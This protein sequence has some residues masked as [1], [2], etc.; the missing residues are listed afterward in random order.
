[1]VNVV[2]S[3]YIYN[4]KFEIFNDVKKQQKQFAFLI[5]TNEYKIICK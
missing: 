1:M 2:M 3:T 5:L 4:K